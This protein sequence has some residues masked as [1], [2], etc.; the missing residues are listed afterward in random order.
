[1]E[2]QEYKIEHGVP[3]PDKVSTNGRPSLGASRTMAQLKSG[4]SF[5]FPSTSEFISQERSLVNAISRARRQGLNIISFKV[6]GGFRI[7]RKPG[8]AAIKHH[9]PAPKARRKA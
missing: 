9:K 1:M 4:D 5:L 6:E 2:Q 8:R 7:F 3:I